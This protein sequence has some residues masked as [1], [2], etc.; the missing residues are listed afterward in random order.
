M[1]SK[2]LHPVVA[3]LAPIEP[4]PTPYDEQHVVT[5]LRLLDAE[6]EQAD[7]EEATRLILRIDPTA[8]PDRARRAFDSHLA[9]AKWLTSQGYPYLLRARTYRS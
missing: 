7:W 5:Y 6:T 1:T 2:S 9:R 3:D 8:E 4:I